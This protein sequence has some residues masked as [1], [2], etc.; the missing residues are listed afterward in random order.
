MG[1]PPF[2]RPAE[3]NRIVPGGRAIPIQFYD[4]RTEHMGGTAMDQRLMTLALQ[5]SLY[6]GTALIDAKAADFVNAVLGP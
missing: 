1:L 6:S 2:A 3:H 4:R 5:Q